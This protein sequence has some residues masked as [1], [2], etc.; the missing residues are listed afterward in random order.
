MRFTVPSPSEALLR[1][2][3]VSQAVA[4]VRQLPT[5]FVAN[6]LLGT[7]V[8]VVYG[9]R[10]RGVLPVRALFTFSDGTTQ[11]FVYPA[12]VWSTNSQHYRREYAFVGKRL[13]QIELDPEQ[14]LLDIDRTNNRW[15]GTRVT[16]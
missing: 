6:P 10:E 4:R 16:P 12:E 13:Q 5:V 1:E 7:F 11:E 2:I 9:N 15:V 14:R 3:R 8:A